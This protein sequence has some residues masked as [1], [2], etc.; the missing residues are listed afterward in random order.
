MIWRSENRDFFMAP[1][2]EGLP[3]VSDFDLN[4]I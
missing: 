4:Y 1:P 2:K 3:E